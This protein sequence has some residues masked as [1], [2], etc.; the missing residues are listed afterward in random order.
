MKRT[1]LILLC[2]LSLELLAQ[3]IPNNSFETWEPQLN[4][5]YE[6]PGGNWWATLNFLRGFGSSAPVTVKKSTSA[7]AGQYAAEITTG[8]FGSF[9][10]PG[11]LVSGTVGEI[12]IVNPTDVIQ[13]GQPFT[14]TPEKLTGYYK[15]SPVNGDSAAAIV[16]LTKYN[17]NTSQ[18]D[19]VAIAETYF[20]T[21]VSTYTAFESILD[22]QM[23]GVTP[24]SITIVLVSSAA[25]ENLAGQPG[26]TLFIDDLA[27]S[28]IQGIEQ[29]VFNT[30]IVQAYPNPTIDRVTFTTAG[31]P[32]ARSVILYDELGRNCFEAPFNNTSIEADISSLANGKYLFA[33]QENSKIVS[34]GTI[35]KTL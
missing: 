23:T 10:I 11:L 26:S 5:T 16:L 18:R 21:S 4:N 19:T 25:A 9:T 3:Q 2:T 22:Y 12:D 7:Q 28:Y 24:D 13:R 30:I 31:P 14:A 1:L 32:A 34:T 33:V 35:L 20:Y 6:E 17:S 15:H 8:T 29:D 27:L